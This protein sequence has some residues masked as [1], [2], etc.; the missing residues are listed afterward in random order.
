VVTSESE[1]EPFFCKDGYLAVDA[2]GYPYAIAKDEFELIYRPMGG[3][4]TFFGL[5]DAAMMLAD[6]RKLD[7]ASGEIARE[8]AMAVTAC[9]DAQ[10]RYTRGRARELDVF[11]PADLDS[12]DALADRRRFLDDVEAARDA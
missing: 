2:R 10:M 3:A 12:V 5:V 4:V 11:R 6:L 8:F 1:N 9:E 7:A